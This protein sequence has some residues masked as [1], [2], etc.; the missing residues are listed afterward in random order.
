M[1]KWLVTVGRRTQ[2]A[3]GEVCKTFTQ[4]FDSA[5]RLQLR[6]HI[7]RTHSF[8]GDTPLHCYSR[9]TQHDTLGV[10]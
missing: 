4:R 3:K 10:Q 1:L 2:V 5:R 8:L 9:R 7:L 6:P